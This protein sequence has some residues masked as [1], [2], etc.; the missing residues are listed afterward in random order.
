MKEQEHKPLLIDYEMLDVPEAGVIHP[1]APLTPE[2]ELRLRAL[3][4]VFLQRDAAWVNLTER[5]ERVRNL[6]ETWVTDDRNR[7]ISAL[8]YAEKTCFG[9]PQSVKGLRGIDVLP[10]ESIEETLGFALR[11]QIP[12]LESKYE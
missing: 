2:E 6:I 3:R 10:L 7:R 11:E 4:I 8:E 12:L 9:R 1:D 5:E